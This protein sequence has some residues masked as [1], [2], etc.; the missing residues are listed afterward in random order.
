MCDVSLSSSI[1]SSLLAD[2]SVCIFLFFC[3]PSAD[4]ECFESF[5]LY[6]SRFSF[7]FDAKHVCHHPVLAFMFIIHKVVLVYL[8]KIRKKMLSLLFFLVQ[9]CCHGCGVLRN[10][11]N[12][13]NKD[14][15][16]TGKSK[17]RI[18]FAFGFL[19]FS[20]SC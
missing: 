20:S 11:N 18:S 19:C 7:N 16:Q 3:F 8:L 1:C 15:R 5:F 4:A 12:N 17:G 10:N 2:S 14:V 13:N 9:D 6:G